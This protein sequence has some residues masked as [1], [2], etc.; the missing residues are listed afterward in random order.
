M[1]P[2]RAKL[3][4]KLVNLP[5]L[6]LEQREKFEKLFKQEIKKT[7]MEKRYPAPKNAI[8]LSNKMHKDES[9]SDFCKRRRK[10]NKRK[11][12]KGVN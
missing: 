2:K 10:T 4:R 11:K 7:K 5:S 3:N 9:Y 1:N 12:L 6:T 8:L